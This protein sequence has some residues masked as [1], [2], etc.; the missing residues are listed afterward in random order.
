[1]YFPRDKQ[2]KSNA[3]K[4]ENVKKKGNLKREPQSLPIAVQDNAIRTISKQE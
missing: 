2:V 4:R 3:R 1:M